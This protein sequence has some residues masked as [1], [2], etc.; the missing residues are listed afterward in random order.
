MAE[1]LKCVIVEDEIMARKS[2]Q[3]LCEKMEQ[4]ELIDSFDNAKDALQKIENDAVDLIFLDIEMPDMTGIELLEQLTVTPQVIFT[5]G[6]KEYAFEA[7]EYDVTDFL[8]KPITQLRF[9]KAVEKAIQRQEQL[10]AIA[11]ASSKNEIYIRTDGRYVRVPF[12]NILYFE[13]VGDYVKVITS[14]GNHIIHGSMKSIDSRIQH[15]RF[16]KVH[17]SYIVNLDKI[18]DIEDNTL[19][20][21]KAVIPISRAHK[22]ILMRTINLL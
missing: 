12:S 19:V 17:R 1:R 16:L 9:A 3:K 20:I 5:T 10:D 22:P 8:K 14:S 11:T 13:N 4:L 2:L 21:D 15:P 7:F 18:K 6:N